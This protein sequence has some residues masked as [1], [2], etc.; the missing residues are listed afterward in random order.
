M[1][2]DLLTP[3]A[4]RVQVHANNWED[5]VRIGGQV[6]VDNGLVTPS[7]IDAMVKTVTEMG[8]YIVIAPGIAMPRARGRCVTGRA[9]PLPL[10]RNR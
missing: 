1:L 9:L 6:M 8:P 4:V 5:V 10:W 7:Y 3:K 2:R